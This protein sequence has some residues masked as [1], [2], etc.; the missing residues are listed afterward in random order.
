M[1]RTPSPPM[2]ARLLLSGLAG[3]C[4]LGLL[5]SL[6]VGAYPLALSDIA[7]LLAAALGV[8]DG[9]ADRTAETVFWSLRVPRA[10]GALLI[11]AAL[12]AS[13][14]C[15][16]RVFR[17]P[18]AAP[19]LLGVSSGA[20][21]GAALAIVAGLGEGGLQLAAF[22]GGLAAISLVLAIGPL[23][24]GRDRLLGLVLTGVAVSSLL[25]AV[26]AALISLADPRSALPAITYWML[27]SFSAISPA[28]LAY[29]AG[30][31]VLALLPM[32]L[33]RWRADALALSDDE[34]LASGVRSPQLRLVLIALAALAT[35]GAVAAAGIIGWVGLVVPHLARMLVG[36]A[37]P[38]V[39]PASAL[40]GAVL[41]VLIDTASRSLGDTE[42]PPGVLA[43]L[44]GAPVLF[45]LLW[46][47]RAD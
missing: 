29:L 6:S 37:F 8:G 28:G 46:S 47:R 13:G 3:A 18:L 30:L 42:L 12:A 17:N 21:L 7:R 25:G 10:L 23:L 22:G 9:T 20:A 14:A 44:L 40:L 15:L 2:S 38:S 1:L 33:L 31:V 36:A 11:G 5:L 32:G 19:E 43:A 45:V 24:P 34:A 4:V 26:L 27:G 41:M 16:Q 39:L 35:A